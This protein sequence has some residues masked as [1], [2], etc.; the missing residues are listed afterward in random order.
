M[1]AHLVSNTLQ[2]TGLARGRTSPVAV[3]LAPVAGA[4]AEEIAGF[5]VQSVAPAPVDAVPTE[6]KRK[7]TRQERETARIVADQAR[8]A[9]GARRAEQMEREAK[10]AWEANRSP[11]PVGFDRSR[12][13]D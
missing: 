5:I 11:E 9:E 3:R 1:W 10:A 2:T 13:V 4:G 8:V 6:P 7:L 12:F